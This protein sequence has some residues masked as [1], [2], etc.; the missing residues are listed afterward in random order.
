[1]QYTT[2]STTIPLLRS[3]F[4][5]RSPR[6]LLLRLI[7]FK[8]WF[9]YKSLLVKQMFINSFRGCAKWRN[10]AAN[11]ITSATDSSQYIM[12][13][14]LNR[15]LIY[16]YMYMDM[17]DRRLCESFIF[18][19]IASYTSR[20]TIYHIK[21]INLHVHSFKTFQ[22]FF[23]HA[24]Y[25]FVRDGIRVYNVHQWNEYQ[26]LYSIRSIRLE[27]LGY[28]FNTMICLILHTV[29]NVQ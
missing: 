24:I 16:N 23:Y 21:L 2:Q 27:S 19:F 1:M 29:C 11:L 17:Q 18:F 22:G 13:K 20:R 14:Y 12:Q 15:T 5:T 8:T 4:N 7:S 3:S 10:V 6:L 9:C 28:M 25:D 26:T